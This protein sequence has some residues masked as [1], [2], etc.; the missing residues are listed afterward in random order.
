MSGDTIRIIFDGPPGAESGR[1]VEV[2]DGDGRGVSVGRWVELPDDG[3]WA[4]ELAMDVKAE[5]A[6]LRKA[7]EG[8]GEGRHVISNIQYRAGFDAAIDYVLALLEVVTVSPGAVEASVTVPSPTVQ[9]PIDISPEAVSAAVDI[10]P[11]EVEE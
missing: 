7:V 9:A 5:R 4:L 11:V 6:R 8:L 1:F 10:E 3:W 2:E